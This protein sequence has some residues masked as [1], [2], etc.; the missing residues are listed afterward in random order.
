[1]SECDDYVNNGSGTIAEKKTKKIPTHG[2]CKQKIA[3][4]KSRERT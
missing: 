4:A 1:M 3:F 2:R